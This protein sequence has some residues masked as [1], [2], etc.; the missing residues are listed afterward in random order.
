MTDI[1]AIGLNHLSNSL[2]GKMGKCEVSEWQGD[3]GENVFIYWEPLTGVQQ[4]K[5]EACSNVVDRIAMT[6][7]VRA[8]DQDRKKVFKNTPLESLVNDYDFSVI[9]A[10]AYLMAS[11]MGGDPDDETEKAAKE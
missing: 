2:A 3:D 7:K 1:A 10:I 11:D 9:R 5:I 8:R 4:K 6:V